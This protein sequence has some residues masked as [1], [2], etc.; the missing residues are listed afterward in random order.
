M[1]FHCVYTGKAENRSVTFLRSACDAQGIPFV[2]QS[3]DAVPLGANISESDL[4]Y[5]VS[6]NNPARVLEQRLL[7]E[8]P[9]NFYDQTVSGITRLDDF[10]KVMLR[11]ANGVPM[12]KTHYGISSDRTYLRS[13]VKQ[14]GG[15]P[16]ILKI[17]G[18]QEGAGVVFV[19]SERSLFSL[20]DF[21][22]KSDNVKVLLM[23]Y[24]PTDR[25]ARL[26][27]LGESVVASVEYIA[28]EGDFRSNLP[29]ESVAD[30]SKRRIP[31]TFA[32]EIRDAAILATKSAGLEFGGVDILMSGNRIYVLEVNFP[33]NFADTQEAT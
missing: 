17:L 23:E 5:R 13:V 31:K 20:S 16:V 29:Y 9:K 4:L 10:G 25:S 3:T 8:N 11:Q 2:L 22:A 1:K 12:P 14:L 28:P 30:M 7:L 32:S 6:V 26:I 18:G 19:D 24:V 21:F 33:C 15:Y 27:V